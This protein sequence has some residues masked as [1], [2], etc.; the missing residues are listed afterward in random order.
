MMTELKTATGGQ[1]TRRSLLAGAGA[2]GAGLMLAPI[3]LMLPDDAEAIGLEAGGAESV[4]DI[5]D[6][7]ATNEAFGVTLV[8][9]V[10]DSAKNGAYTSP[11][12]QKVLRILHGVRAEEQLH[13]DFL[14]RAGAKL[15]THTFYLADPKVL[16]DPQT[17]FMDLV[18]L[19]D[20]AI[21][22]V[23]A[24][25]PTF[26][27]ARRFDLVKKNFQFAT[28]E[29]EHRLLANKALGTSPPNDQAFA[30]AMY[31][32]VTEFYATL[33]KKGIIGGPGKQIT[34]PG[35]AAIDYHNVI[36]RTPRGPSA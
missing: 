20:A 4:Q 30:P 1:F 15:R 35:P 27:R 17:L 33:K 23:M 18:E 22:A 10:L 32:T 28:E 12:P 7:L 16:T 21:A 3:K 5:L 24:S 31:Q 25:M 2:I 13:L 19:E 9:T 14:L 11:I 34:Y 29:S 36:Y 6:I 8:A 26:T